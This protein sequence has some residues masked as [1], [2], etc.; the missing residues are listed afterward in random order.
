ME[1]GLKTGWFYADI[2]LP[3]TVG[4]WLLIR[5]AKGRSTTELDELFE[6][7]IKPRRFSKAETE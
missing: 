6:R 1:L 4:M 2:G 7:K 5:E 3:A